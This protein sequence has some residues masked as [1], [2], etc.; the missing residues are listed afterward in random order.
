MAADDK[1]LETA[2]GESLDDV[3]TT[4]RDTVHAHV[5][6]APSSLSQA[7]AELRTEISNLQNQLGTQNTQEN[8]GALL[9]P[10][11]LEDVITQTAKPMLAVILKDWV[12][13]HL[14]PLAE[15]IIREEIDKIAR[16]IKG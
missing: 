2:S 9:S 5:Q 13:R 12:D 8:R 11:V 4:I 7:L 16:E 1:N 3:L 15:Q 6:G 14:P 10:E